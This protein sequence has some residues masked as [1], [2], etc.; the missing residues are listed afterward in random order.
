MLKDP[1]RFTLDM[2]AA[3][4]DALQATAERRGLSVAAVVRAA[5][6]KRLRIWES[7]VCC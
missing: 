3:D 7:L 1:V 5:I 2:D 6:K 4:H